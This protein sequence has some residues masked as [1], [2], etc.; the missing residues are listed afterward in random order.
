MRLS[1]QQL[2]RAWDDKSPKWDEY[3]NK[4]SNNLIE[5]IEHLSSIASEFSNF[6]EIPKSKSEVVNVITKIKKSVELFSNEENID[7]KLDLNDKNKVFIYFDKEKMVQVFSNLINNAIQS[8]PD[9]RRGRI[10]ISLDIIDKN[11]LV[12]I[13]DN[14][15]GI[16]KEIGDK[17]FEPNFTTKTSGMG[18]GLA[19]VKNIME[20]AGGRI[21]Y[22]T[23]IGKGS[24]FIIEMPLHLPGKNAPV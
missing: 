24:T 4:F 15:S 6:A 18:L 5:Q 13:A 17:L 9:G 22:E 10:T 14:G 19:I 11:V 23:E 20:D 3:L 8:I 1:V 7:F 16:P 2:Q 12:K 21:W